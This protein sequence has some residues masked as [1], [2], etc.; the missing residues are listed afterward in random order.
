VLI[1]VLRE[2]PAA[3][4][5][6]AEAAALGASASE[7]TRYEILAGLRSGEEE[8]TEDLLAQLDWVPVGESIARF[9]AALAREFRA[10]TAGIEDG[11]YLIAATALELGEPL[12]TRNVR[13]FPMFPGLEPAY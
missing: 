10:G 2:V 12:L 11:D 4:E 3:V 5:V 1:D 7:V 6:V 13:H 8:R 9:A